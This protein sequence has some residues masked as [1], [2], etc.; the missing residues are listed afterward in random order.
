MI[1]TDRERVQL[2]REKLI[3]S[4]YLNVLA[5]PGTPTLNRAL[6]SVMVTETLS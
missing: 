4:S 6:Y 2:G 3:I 5:C 1:H